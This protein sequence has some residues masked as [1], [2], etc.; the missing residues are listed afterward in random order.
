MTSTQS[1]ATALSISAAMA[2]STLTLGLSAT[3]SNASTIRA[4]NANAIGQTS[5]INKV[6][7]KSAPGSASS[8]REFRNNWTFVAPNGYM[9]SSVSVRKLSGGKNA[10]YSEKWLPSGGSFSSRT[11]SSS[12]YNQSLNF[13]AEYRGSM[14]Y[15]R[16][17]AAYRNAGSQMSNWYNQVNSGQQGSYEFNMSVRPNSASEGLWDMWQDV[18]GKFRIDIGLRCVGD[19]NTQRTY[20]QNLAQRLVRQYNLTK[21]N[22]GNSGNSGNSGNTG[23]SGNI[24]GSNYGAPWQKT[25]YKLAGTWK[26]N[27]GGTYTIKQAG[28][29]ITWT[30][31]GGN[32]INKFSGTISGRTICGKW[33]DTA[34]SQ[35]Q[36]K[37]TLKLRINNSGKL[38]RIRRTGP[39]TGSQWTRVGRNTGNTGNTGNVSQLREDCLPFNPRALSLSNRGGTGGWTITE[40]N[41]L[42]FAFGNNKAQAKESLKLIKGYGF[43][44]SC[45]VGRPGPSMR[46][47]KKGS[48]V[49]SFSAS[50]VKPRDCININNR[51]LS[52][53]KN[54]ANWALT[55]GRS[56]PLSSQ[57]KSEMVQAKGIIKKY[58]LSKQCFVGR[59]NAPFAFWLR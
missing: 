8:S 37:G 16:A 26:A 21:S 4:C 32:F 20:Y 6:I 14:G 54:G 5:R 59:P 18:N 45:F 52:L 24:C 34:Q 12:A 50:A 55:D 2:A 3:P 57:S 35:T 10:S 23:N 41:R 39:F 36:N 31:R 28:N 53:R 47:L 15:E 40:G 29:R 51:T 46:Y 27:D 56:I 19:A 44:Q 48:S 42:L 11:Q 1:K 22:T 33:R 43:N 58:G 30:G 25:K 7:Q 49:P 13:L 9:I 38:T 17:S